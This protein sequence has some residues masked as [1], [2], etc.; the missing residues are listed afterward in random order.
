MKGNEIARALLGA[1]LLAG[2]A[3]ASAAPPTAAAA[4]AAPA[5][6]AQVAAL[7]RL[8]HDSD[9]ANL[10]LNPLN[11]LFR[12]DLRFANR[13]G[14]YFSDDYYARSAALARSDLAGLA[15]IDRSTLPP[16]DQI[17]YDVF[18]WQRQ[19]DLAGYDPA[20]LDVTKVRPL[21]H[22]NGLQAIVPDLFSAQGVAP[23]RT[24]KDYDD[25]L[26]RLDGFAANLAMAQKRME[27]GLAKEI[28]QP[29]IV[30]ERVLGQLDRFIAAGVDGSTLMQA[31]QNFPDTVPA[32][33]RKRLAAGYRAKMEKVILPAYVRLRDFVRD[34]YLP[35][36]RPDDHPG[37]ASMP[38]GPLLYRYL[39]G[40][41]T[42]TAMAPEEIHKVGLSEVAR[43]TAEMDAVKREVG[44]QG[45][46][47]AFFEYLR[48]DPRFKLKSKAELTAGY[49]AIARRVDQ[50]VGRLFTVV[51]KS[52]LEV[53]PVPDYLEKDQA[54]GYYYPGTP[55]GSR[56]GVFYYNGYDLPSRTTPGMETLYLHEGIP[57]H[58]FQISL[59]QENDRLP[60]FQ[61]F[62]GNTAFVEGWALYAESLGRELGMLTD[63]Y[64][65][66]G[67][68]DDEMLRA[69]RLVVDTGI[70]F[71][72][73]SR[74]QA[75]RYMLDNSSMGETDA[76]NE[77]DRYIA[78]PAQALAYK[79]GELRIRAA[80]TRAEKALGK[81]FDVR[82]FHAE[83]LGSGALPLDVLDAK[84]DRWIAGQRGNAG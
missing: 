37:L 26:A 32:A 53:R 7:H 81:R 84:I 21:D 22:F 73:W 54:G 4:A 48:T 27:E 10:V 36:S 39:V 76:T 46:L 78:M 44:F 25:N 63:P 79:T 30:S 66:F 31:V 49:Q 12:G 28:V 75:I 72:G 57:G 58:H 16:D 17:S 18:R 2:S 51:P 56:P 50:A 15:R 5:R 34:R 6:D 64:Q 80:R 40:V 14:D 20:I 24:V 74:A 19:T 65:Y 33:D 52:P 71:K 70:H 9:E 1:A 67:R 11:A 13:F 29:R 47:R 8:F 77:V 83:V 69:M 43:I 38:G 45:D 3:L 59:A 62:G 82:A 60:A 42:T 68:L 41:Q 23:F 55:D 35:A 61:R